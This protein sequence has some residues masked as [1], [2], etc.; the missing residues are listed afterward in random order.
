LSEV[1][2]NVAGDAPTGNLTLTIF[3]YQS[4]RDFFTPHY[5]WEPL[6]TVTIPPSNISQAFAVV[7]VPVGARVG[8]L[9]CYADVCVD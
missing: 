2:V 1:G 4:N 9:E 7:R 6:T 3:R 5:I 8:E